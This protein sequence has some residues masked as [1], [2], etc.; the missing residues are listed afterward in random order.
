M[1]GFGVP[2]LLPD[3]VSLFSFSHLIMFSGLSRAG[4]ADVSSINMLEI[5]FH[6]LSQAMEGFSQWSSVQP[7][8]QTVIAVI[9]RLVPPL[10]S[11]D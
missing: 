2:A 6:F 11:I 1:E 5:V 3:E 8:V 4:Q 7:F 10:Y 9:G